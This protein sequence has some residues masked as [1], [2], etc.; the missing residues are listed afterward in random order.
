LSVSS[1]R[2]RSPR[3]LTS[4]PPRRPSDLTLDGGASWQDWAPN[5][6]NPSG[7]HLNG[8]ARITGDALVVVG[9]AG[10]IHSSV[11]GG[12]TWEL[13]DSPDRKSTRLNSSHVKTSY[14]VLCLKKI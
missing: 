11:D 3:S 2:F 10:Q 9:E 7:Y 5:L 1:T 13:R 12:E 8:I 14:A 6:D 4:S